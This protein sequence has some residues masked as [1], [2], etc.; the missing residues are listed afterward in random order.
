[1]AVGVCPYTEIS[2]NFL[3]YDII[4]IRLRLDPFFARRPLPTPHRP[5]SGV[6]KDR[7][8]NRF[9]LD[10]LM[11]I[12]WKARVGLGIRLSLPLNY[13]VCSQIKFGCEN[14]HWP[15]PQALSPSFSNV[16]QQCMQHWKAGERASDEARLQYRCFLPCLVLSLV[17]TIQIALCWTTV[18]EGEEGE[19]ETDAVTLM[20]NQ[21]HLPISVY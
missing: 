18:M 12:H 15:R 14:H 5:C 13:I 19:E 3:F 9:L 16:T 1:M 21:L 10:R 2:G 8:T 7:L 17:L 20:T 6:G 4:A 11:L